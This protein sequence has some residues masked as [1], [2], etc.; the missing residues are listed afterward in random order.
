MR[1]KSR[2]ALKGRGYKAEGEEGE[3]E[4]EGEGAEEG[5][6]LRVEK[7]GISVNFPHAQGEAHLVIDRNEDGFYLSLSLSMSDIY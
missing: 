6:E 4:G 2:W 7:G 1:R 3:G 5:C